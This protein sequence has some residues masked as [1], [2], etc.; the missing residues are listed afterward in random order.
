MGMIFIGRPIPRGS[1]SSG[2]EAQPVASASGRPA[3]TACWAV[4]RCLEPI[5]ASV[6]HVIAGVSRVWQAVEWGIAGIHAWPALR[7]G[8]EG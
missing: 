8:I 7:P 2:P 5:P 3:R 1:T 4:G 6:L